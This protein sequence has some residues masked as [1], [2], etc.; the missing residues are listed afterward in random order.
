MTKPFMKPIPGETSFD[1]GVRVV[2][3]LAETFFDWATSESDEAFAEEIDRKHGTNTREALAKAKAK[4]AD[5]KARV[6]IPASARPAPESEPATSRVLARSGSTE[7]LEA[8]S[9][10]EEDEVVV[11]IDETPPCAFCKGKPVVA[12]NRA[13]RSRTR[14][15]CPECG[16]KA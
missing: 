11:I 6:G 15:A 5:G 16:Q 1:E 2:G 8:S 14:I 13:T 4:I 7:V 10:T 12:L 9:T 3:K